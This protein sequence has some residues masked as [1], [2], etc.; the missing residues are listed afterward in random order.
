M[1][2]FSG[3]PTEAE[4]RRFMDILFESTF[5]ENENMLHDETLQNIYPMNKHYVSKEFQK[6]HICSLFQYVINNAER[7]IYN[8][9]CVVE[10]TK[11]YIEGE[12]T[13]ANWYKENYDITGDKDDILKIKDMFEDYKESDDYKN[14]RKDERPTLHRFLHQYVLTDNK[15]SARYKETLQYR[16]EGKMKK[17]RTV[18][19]GMK[20][21]EVDDDEYE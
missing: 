12:D 14:M 1:L 5:T 20:L 10:R 2:L 6:S 7:Q 21:K 18:L 17:H 16:L 3:K 4:T 13:F 8:P 11:C 15:L 9:P 19:V